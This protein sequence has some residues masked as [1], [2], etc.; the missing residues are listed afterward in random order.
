[1][2]DRSFLLIGIEKEQGVF[3][4]CPYRSLYAI[5]FNGYEFGLLL[6]VVKPFLLCG[7]N[8]D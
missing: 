4:P 1:M 3:Q 5:Q 6:P 7:L 8:G 2:S